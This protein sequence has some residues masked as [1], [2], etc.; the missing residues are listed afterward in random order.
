MSSKKQ[1]TDTIKASIKDR[2]HPL[3]TQF[4]LMLVSSCVEGFTLQGQDISNIVV[5][6]LRTLDDV[7]KFLEKD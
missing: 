5:G 3:E 7:Y 4:R 2:L 6:M 1:T